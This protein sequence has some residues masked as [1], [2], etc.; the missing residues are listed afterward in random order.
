M[1]REIDLQGF[2][3][4]SVEAIADLTGLTPEQAAMAKDREFSEP[5]LLGSEDTLP[6]LQSLATAKGMKIVTGGRFHHLIGAGQDKGEAVKLVRAAL[7]RQEGTKRLAIGLG[8][9]DNDLPMLMAVDVPVLIP[10]PER[11][12]L[13][14]DLPRMV[15]A[16]QPGMQGMERGDGKVARWFTRQNILEMFHA[17]LGCGEARGNGTAR[18]YDSW[19]NPG[20]RG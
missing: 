1:R 5:F 17:A 3:D 10:H 6:L 2:G 20:D 18:R 16:T 19:G 8:D 11:G 7:E 14:V 12:L 13:P 9:S 15:C 4:L